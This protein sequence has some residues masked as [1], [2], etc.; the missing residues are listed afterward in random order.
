M[1][2]LLEALR[3]RP[4]GAAL[5]EIAPPNA[6]LVG[7]TVRDLLLGREPRELDVVVEG[8]PTELL[9]AL[10]RV[11]LHDQFATAS[12]MLAGGRVDVARARR[13]RYRGPGA[14]PDVEP[15]SLA[16]DLLRRD[17]TINAIAMSLDSGELHPAPRALEDLAARRL[18]VFHDA[19]FVDD[20]T[21]LI[22]LAR[23]A[24]R[25]G[26]E[27]EPR[28]AA[29]AAQ[30]SF[31]ALSGARL[32]D[33]LRNALAEPDPVAV[34]R[35]LPLGF[36]AELALRASELLPPD[37]DRGLLL[38]ACCAAL[39][40]RLDT[41][42]LTV[43]ERAAVAHGYDAVQIAR[44]IGAASRPSQLY[45]ALRG[46][47]VEAIALAGALGEADGASR[48]L[49]ELRH[50]R[51]EI[52]GTDLLHAGVPQGPEIGERLARTLARKLDGE[53]TGGREEEL[54]EALE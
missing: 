22:R 51:L 19:S 42:E 33:E 48:W 27:V 12:A 28:T 20:P 10:D 45:A 8:D 40:P 5:L 31:D 13:E 15:A 24:E 38:L 36:D 30:A 14:L 9:T 21:R 41:L 50:V 26:L 23:Y 34:L 2:E 3:R 35:R 43:R 6:Y 46:E 53:L 39:R 52:N 54:K 32:G 47:P 25:L 44:R 18:R 37:G 7:G 17:F 4:D 1:S 49:R 16:E 11:V 29:L